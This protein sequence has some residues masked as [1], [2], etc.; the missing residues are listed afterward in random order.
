MA[1]VGGQPVLQALGRRQR[2]VQRDDGQRLRQQGPEALGEA[3]FELRREVDLGH[4]HQHLATCGKCSFG[5]AQI[6][7]G[8]AAASDAKQEQRL[9]RSASQLGL[10]RANRLGLFGRQRGPNGLGCCGCRARLARQFAKPRVQLLPAQFMQLRRQHRARQFADAALV[11]ARREVQQPAPVHAQGRQGIE[12]GRDRLERS[13]RRK[14]V[15]TGPDH[16]QQLALAEW[17]AHQRSRRKHALT[18]VVQRTA[19]AAVLGRVDG[20]LHHRGSCR[21]SHAKLQPV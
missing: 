2:T 5:R 12:D 17:R 14:P 18:G 11:V 6:D 8:L 16:A 19:E 10:D 4:Q 15:C 21:F 20:H 3:G 1:K 13:L 9:D 7:L